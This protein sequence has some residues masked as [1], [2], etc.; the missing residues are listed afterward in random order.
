MISISWPVPSFLAEKYSWKIIA[1]MS[2]DI[3]M[4]VSVNITMTSLSLVDLSITIVPPP[5]IAVHEYFKTLKNSY[6]NWK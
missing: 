6:F 1:N 3:T 4:S 5:E 2:Q